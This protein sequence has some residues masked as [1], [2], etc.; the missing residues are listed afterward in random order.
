MT[1]AFIA[2]C[3]GTTLTP[4]EV[5]FFRDA[6]PW[7]FILF[8]RNIDHPEQVRALCDALARPS[9]GPMRRS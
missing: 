7:G 8:K 9:A 1:R 3:S 2:G 4:D 5:A 6:A